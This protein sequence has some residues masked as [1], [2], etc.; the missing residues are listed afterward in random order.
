MNPMSASL[1]LSAKLREDKKSATLIYTSNAAPITCTTA[2]PPLVAR[3]LIEPFEYTLELGAALYQL[4]DGDTRQLTQARERARRANAPLHLQLQLDAALQDLPFELL[5]DGHFLAP[6]EIHLIRQASDRGREHAHAP[7]NRQLKLLFIACSPRG[8]APELDFEKE[9]E[10]IYRATDKLPLEI[11]VEDSGSLEGLA[12]RLVNESF[13]IIHLS[14]H[15]GLDKNGLPFFWM[16]DDEGEPQK[17]SPAGLWQAL[18]LHPPHVLFLAGCQTGQ[19]DPNAAAGSFAQQ[20]VAEGIPTVLSWGRPVYDLGATEAA[21]HLY[22]ELS[23]GQNLAE[24]VA[25]TRER[26]AEARHYAINSVWPLLRL[27]RDAAAFAPLVTPGQRHKP[28]PRKL[29]HAYLANGK[30]KILTEGFVGRRRQLQTG[31]RV[32]RHGQDDPTQPRV[33]VLLHGAAGLGKSCL[34]GKLLERLSGHDTTAIIV[35]GRLDAITLIPALL[36]AYR[37]APDA[38]AEAILAERKELPEKLAA[39]C[40]R[41]LK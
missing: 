11:L 1:H 35:H 36:D 17:I 22:F 4:L 38:E 30:V 32:L 39:L 16:E 13:D 23:R 21:K 27:F 10:A 2:L 8:L 15:A 24:A 37:R 33:G 28:T 26:L 12:E 34:A 3:A 18:R 31:L 19:A 7:A 14:G 20:L 29:S 9:E 5:H 25:A 40:S 41:E 6:R